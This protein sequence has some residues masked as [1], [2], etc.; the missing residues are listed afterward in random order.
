MDD[1]FFHLD[2]SDDDGVSDENV[3]AC[4]HH[5]DDDN[6]YATRDVLAAARMLG[7]NAATIVKGNGTT[8]PGM[9]PLLHLDWASSVETIMSTTDQQLKIDHLKALGLLAQI[10]PHGDPMREAGVV[11]VVTDCLAEIETGGDKRVAIAAAEAMRHLACANQSNRIAGREAG[12]IPRLVAMLRSVADV[13]TAVT[14]TG[15]GDG[16]DNNTNTS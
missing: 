14:T 1:D 5:N 8:R 16:A 9:K 3:L 12:A 7:P 10:P 2:L 11:R 13:A 6:S 4:V 15:E